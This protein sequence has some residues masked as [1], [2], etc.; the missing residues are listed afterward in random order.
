VTNRP[1]QR[2]EK[3]ENPRNFKNAQKTRKNWL[4]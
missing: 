2:A 1:P 3:T 4:F